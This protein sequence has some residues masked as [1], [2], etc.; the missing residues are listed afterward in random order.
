MRSRTAEISKVQDA[1][2]WTQMMLPS[3]KLVKKNIFLVVPSPGDNKN[4][5]G[6]ANFD[7]RIL[8]RH[9]KTSNWLLMVILSNLKLG[10]EEESFS[11][12]FDDFFLSTG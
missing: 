9:V 2:F 1:V 4:L 6:L 11:F 7:F 3:W 12:F 5:A 8:W 10:I